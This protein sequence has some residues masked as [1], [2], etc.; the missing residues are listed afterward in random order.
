MSYPIFDRFGRSESKARAQ[1][2]LNNQEAALR[3]ARLTAQANILQQLGALRVAEEQIRL[4][5]I[6]IEAAEEDLR[7]QQVRYQLAAGLLVEVLTS[8][9]A[10][11]NARSALIQ[12]RLNY[13]TAR[14]QI[15]AIIGRDLP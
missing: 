14:A 6:S 8:Q 7:V 1:V 2:T 12:A 15:E 9:T 11:N 4:N 3:E 10:L 13:R 5:Q